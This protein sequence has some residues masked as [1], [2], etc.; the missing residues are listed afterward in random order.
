MHVC[1]DIVCIV[2]SVGW[3]EGGRVIPGDAGAD[4]GWVA[5]CDDVGHVCD[6][7]GIIGPNPNAVSSQ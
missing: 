4:V 7:T 1:L 6:I 2:H 5:I 3:V